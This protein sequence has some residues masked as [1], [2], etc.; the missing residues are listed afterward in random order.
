MM[1]FWTEYFILGHTLVNR[2]SDEYPL[3]DIT[4]PFVHELKAIIQEF[5]MINWYV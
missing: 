1:A 4:V 2:Y 5:L 3:I